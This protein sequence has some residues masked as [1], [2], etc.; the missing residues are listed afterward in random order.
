MADGTSQKLVLAKVV[1]VCL[2]LSLSLS[3]SFCEGIERAPSPLDDQMR[4]VPGSQT[5][6]QTAWLSQPA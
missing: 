3:L 4:D 1:A 2:S 6:E 5:D